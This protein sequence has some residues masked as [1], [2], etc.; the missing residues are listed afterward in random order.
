MI[1]AEA[2]EYTALRQK[3]RKIFKDGKKLT[4]EEFI[5]L[6][7]N[8]YSNMD[9]MKQVIT[10]LGLQNAVLAHYTRKHEKHETSWKKVLF[11][12]E[13]TMQREHFF[14]SKIVD[15]NRVVFPL[16]PQCDCKWNW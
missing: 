5:N 16:A 1:R 4:F 14:L 15:A 6:T 10:K 12:H 11:T 2:T 9:S 8:K 7:A 3:L 13:V